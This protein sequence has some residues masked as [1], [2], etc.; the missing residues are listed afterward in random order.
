MEKIINTELIGIKKLTKQLIK[1]LT[2][3]RVSQNKRVIITG[4]GKSG[5]SKK[6][7]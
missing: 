2:P 1:T 4:V 7:I 5:H 3:V 6:S